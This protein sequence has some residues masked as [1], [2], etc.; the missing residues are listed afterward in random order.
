MTF[1]VKGLAYQY[2]LI[3]TKKKKF[4]YFVYCFVIVNSA[5]GFECLSTGVILALWCSGYHYSHFNSPKSYFSFYAVLH[6]FSSGSRR[7]KGLRWTEH[8]TLVL[9]RI[10][11]NAFLHVLLHKNNSLFADHL[12]SYHRSYH[13]CSFPVTEITLKIDCYSM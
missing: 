1:S 5:F 10:K 6:G 13:F 12:R 4:L 11:L 3:E 8:L 9:E 2:L 7:I